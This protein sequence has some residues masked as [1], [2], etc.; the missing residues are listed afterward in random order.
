MIRAKE[1]LTSVYKRF[2]ILLL[3]ALPEETEGT[4]VFRPKVG[5]EF[6]LQKTWT[7]LK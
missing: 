6:N 3:K 7:N 1:S 2:Y 4:E 5:Q